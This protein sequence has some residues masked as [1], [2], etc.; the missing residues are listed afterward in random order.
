MN[1]ILTLSVILHC[2]T[3][4]AGNTEGDPV[5]RKEYMAM[6]ARFVEFYQAGE[7]AKGVALLDS[8]I[9]LYPDY[10]RAN[11][12]NLALAHTHLEQYDRGVAALARPLEEGIFY[13]VWDFNHET[14][15]PYRDRADFRA[16]IVRS[17]ALLN[18][19]Q[20]AAK[21]EIV[22][23]VPH[24]YVAGRVYP[25]FVALHGG[26]DSIA[27]FKDNWYS[28]RMKSDFIVAYLQSSQLVGMDSYNWTE[29]I[30]ITKREITEAYQ[31]IA[32]EYG[33]IEDQTIVGGFSSG[34]VAALEIALEDAFPIA[35]FIALCPAKPEGFIVERLAAAKVRGLRGTLLTTEMD[36]RVADQKEMDAMMTAAGLPHQFDITPNIGHWFPEDIDARIDQA[37]EFI[38]Q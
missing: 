3:A 36:H 37:I 6:R 35:G 16:L 23:D 8:V 21:A 31:K 15:D 1:R 19:A 28:P 17:D 9:G 32:R 27:K 29:D 30:A 18:E 12:Y 25:L 5:E 34:G 11:S 38:L 20:R 2:A 26:G 4:G 22:M 24:N 33:L 7:Y 13:G 10:I 14:W